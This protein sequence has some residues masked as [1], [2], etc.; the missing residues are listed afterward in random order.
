MRKKLPDSRDS[1]T[2]EGTGSNQRT[3]TDLPNNHIRRSSKHNR[4]TEAVE[5]GSPQT[6]PKNK[7]NNQTQSKTGKNNVP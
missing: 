5:M 3:N 4:T 7:N 6:T 1:H 2:M